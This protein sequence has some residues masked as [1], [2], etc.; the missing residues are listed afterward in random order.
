[1]ETKS[2][3][4]QRWIKAS[5]SHLFLSHFIQILSNINM[6]P[7]MNESIIISYELL[8]CYSNNLRYLSHPYTWNQCTK[9]SFKLLIFDPHVFRCTYISPTVNQNIMIPFKLPTFEP[10]VR[11]N[12]CPINKNQWII[13][14]FKHSIFDTNVLRWTYVHIHMN[15]NIIIEFNLHIFHP[16]G[17]KWPFVPLNMKEDIIITF[18]LIIFGPN[19]LRW[20]KLTQTWIKGS[21][22]LYTP[23][24]CP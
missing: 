11:V 23:H 4:P 22:F 15:Q 12:T 21:W 20:P 7:K 17:H 8:I 18:K 9:T 24:I 3:L 19:V 13:N 14:Q 16:N 1:M 10:N 2:L 5:W 6:F